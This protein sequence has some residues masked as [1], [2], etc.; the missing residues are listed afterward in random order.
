MPGR[1][2]R[3]R[4]ERELQAEGQYVCGECGEEIVV[5]LDPTGGA[6]QAYVEDC[7]VCCRPHRIEVEFDEDGSVRVRAEPE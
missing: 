2:R 5:P 6:E 1:K 4:R 7:P 3:V